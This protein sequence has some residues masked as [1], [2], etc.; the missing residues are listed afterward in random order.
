MSKRGFISM[1]EELD[2]ALDMANKE[3]QKTLDYLDTK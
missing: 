1:S 3:I 2:K